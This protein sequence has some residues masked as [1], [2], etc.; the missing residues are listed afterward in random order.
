M[1]IEERLSLHLFKTSIRE[2]SIRQ[3][4]RE[5]IQTLGSVT[6]AWETAAT[7]ITHNNDEY[8]IKKYRKF[9]PVNRLLQ[10]KTISMHIVNAY[11]YRNKTKPA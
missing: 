11:S 7:M 9:A 5:R 10:T 8:R 1:Q 4:T 6:S 2:R 3:T